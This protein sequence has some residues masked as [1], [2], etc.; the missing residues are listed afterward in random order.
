MAL[1]IEID[2]P[3]ENI[4]D[5][6]M[7]EFTLDIDESEENRKKIFQNNEDGSYQDDG[8]SGNRTREYFEYLKEV[9]YS[10]YETV[11]GIIF[12][13]YYVSI[14]YYNQNG[15]DD[16]EDV[17]DLSDFRYFESSTDVVHFLE[18]NPEFF[19][20]M[21]YE[22]L[23]FC[24]AERNEKRK[25][26]NRCRGMEKYLLAINPFHL[27]DKINYCRNYTKEDIILKQREYYTMHREN[28]YHNNR[29]QEQIIEENRLNYEAAIYDTAMFLESVSNIN[30]N[31]YRNLILDIAEDYYIYQI[32]KSSN[33]ALINNDLVNSIKNDSLDDFIKKTTQNGMVLPE[34]I[35]SLA[36]YHRKGKRFKRQVNLVFH[37]CVKEE[38][39]KKVLS[40]DNKKK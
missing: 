20:P 13:D 4:R 40:K 22:S 21:M 14:C 2:N 3:G 29:T 28:N 34:M 17:I 8:E 6:I 39:N 10:Y 33:G 31:N 18:D 19:M 12:V 27:L 25:M 15:I 16:E 9:N 24:L 23:E 36:E 38:A 30:E 1:Y 7:D 5:A 35:A 11:I 26:L 32:Y 37:Q